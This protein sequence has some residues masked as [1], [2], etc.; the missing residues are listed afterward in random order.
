MSGKVGRN[1]IASVS[2]SGSLEQKLKTIADAGYDD[3]E[4]FEPDLIASPHSPRS[5]GKMLGDLGLHCALYQ[6]FRDFEGLPEPLRGLAFDRIERKFDLMGELDCDRILI[7][8]SCSPEASA[9]VSRIHADFD[10]L[11]QR[12]KKRGIKLGYEALAWGRHV[13]DHRQA[14]EVVRA[15]DHPN[16]GIILDSFHSLARGIPVDTLREIDPQKIVF[17]QLADAP[18]LPMDYLY[19]SRHF[20]SLPGQGD[21]PVRQYVTEL[22]AAGYQGPLS[23][24]IFNDRFR[25]GSAELVAKDGLRSLIALRD[26][27]SARPK[28]PPR[29]PIMGVEFVEFALADD[30]AE[31]FEPMLRGLGFA[32]VGSHKSGKIH[33]W[34]HQTINLVVNH[35]E[36]GVGGAYRRTHGAGICAIG[37]RVPDAKVALHRAKELGIT[38]RS[39]IAGEDALLSPAIEAVGNTTIYLLDDAAAGDIWSNHFVHTGEEPAAHPYLS[40]F[41]HLAISVEIDEFLSWQLCW[42]SLFEVEKMSD[43]EVA[44]PAGLVQ[45]CALESADGKFR[46]LLNAAGGRDTLTSRFVSRISSGGF[47]IVALGTSNALDAAR[48]A[49]AGGVPLVDFPANYYDDL[50]A[51]GQLGVE[52]AAELQQADLLFERSNDGQYFEVV[53][54]AFDKRFFFEIVE[55][56]DY[57]GF[58]ERNAPVRIA[59]QARFKEN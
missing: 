53:T 56:D 10:N 31:R 26:A 11:A 3:V 38:E 46:I 45:T 29:I 37:L 58:G 44:D 24:E 51:S 59:A 40:G 8:S 33:H 41:D 32:R 42:L 35:S 5:I 22:L 47:Q 23:L 6:P 54:R 13:Y 25:A 14:W 28:L 39:P 12:A 1:S 9:D 55:R 19:W 21:L 16:L 49:K 4:I 30:E 20:R 27:A 7:C 48:L 15:V 18:R 43:L 57:R 34:K 17:V 50:V 52:A 2:I 36:Q